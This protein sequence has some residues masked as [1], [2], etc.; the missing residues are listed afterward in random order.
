MGLIGLTYIFLQKTE[1]E[2]IW[3]NFFFKKTK[4]TDLTDLTDIFQNSYRW[5]EPKF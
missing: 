5:T 4:P 1:T 2:P 3:P